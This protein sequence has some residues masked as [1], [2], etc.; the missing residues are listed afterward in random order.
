MKKQIPQVIQDLNAFLDGK[1]YLGVV[2]EVQLPAIVQETVETKGGV[3]AKYATGAISAMEATLKLNILD[4]NTYL[5]FGLNT[6]ENR[7]PIILKGSIY[8][9]GNSKPLV[10]VFT[11]DIESI[12]PSAFKAGEV[13]E[14]EIKLQVQFY[15][16]TIGD[17][18]VVVI[19]SRNMICMIG[20]VDYLGDLR[21]N[22]Q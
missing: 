2:S 12:T 4:A 9:D 22:L 13:I 15:S 14:Q 10:V 18:P 3:G 1:G 5:S 21:S 8:D 7:I 16:L 17:I 11:A 20:G 19:D 6:F